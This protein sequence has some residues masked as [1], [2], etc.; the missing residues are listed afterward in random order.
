MAKP[1]RAEGIVAN[2]NNEKVIKQ[3]VEILTQTVFLKG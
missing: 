3:A 2:W 1:L